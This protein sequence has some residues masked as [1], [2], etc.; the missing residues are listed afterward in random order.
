GTLEAFASLGGARTISAKVS[1]PIG[2]KVSA[3]YALF[4]DGGA[5]CAAVESAQAAGI[6]LLKKPDPL[7]ASTFGLGEIILS[8]YARG[9]RK[10]IVGL[11]GSATTD[12]GMGMLASLGAEFFDKSGKPLR[13]FGGGNLGKVA[14]AD[15]SK[16][17]KFARCEFTILCDVKN[18]LCGKLGAAAVFSP[19]KGA[20]KKQAAELE[21]GMKIYARAVA[22]ARGADFSKRE[23]AGA[24]GGL[25][26]AFMA[27]LGAEK[28]SGIDG[29]L[30]AVGFDRRIEGADI[31]VTGEGRL[32]SQSAMG[33][34]PCG[35]A[36]RAKA[37]AIPVI[38]LGGGV[39]DGAETLY[40][41]GVSAMFPIVRA[42]V[43]L[44]E[45]LGKNNA[46][47]NLRLCAESVFRLAK[48]FLK[49]L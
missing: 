32:D 46:R 37:R 2:K 16:L 19:Q 6:T 13:S 28:K 14:R 23:G 15:F 25:G 38:A 47:K 41:C 24:A 35:V 18:P 36:R 4:K 30:D 40:K 11:G 31:V 12:G 48:T 43:S 10:F 21:R 1:D 22:K 26:F 34:T 44:A 49:Q 5:L 33:K 17:S 39:A 20:D 42:P 8:A 27:A 29:V 3:K 45:A 9:A 7:G